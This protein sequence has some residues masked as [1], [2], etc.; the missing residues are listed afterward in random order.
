MSVTNKIEDFQAFVSVWYQKWRKKRSKQVLNLIP[1]DKKMGNF[2]DNCFTS[3]VICWLCICEKCSTLFLSMNNYKCPKNTFFYKV[4]KTIVRT[5]AIMQVTTWVG[6]SCQIIYITFEHNA[7]I[8]DIQQLRG[9]NFTQ[10]WSPTLPEW[11]IVDNCGHFTWYRLFVYVTKR[12]FST[13]PHPPL[14]VHVV[15]EWS[16]WGS[17][18]PWWTKNKIFALSRSNDQHFYAFIP[19]ETHHFRGGLSLSLRFWPTLMH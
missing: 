16:L 3:R 19:S 2:M 5:V 13:D 17:T 9:P 12:G 7:Y 8:G 4:D 1:C 15:I 18:G 10:F 14:L 6:S 11:T